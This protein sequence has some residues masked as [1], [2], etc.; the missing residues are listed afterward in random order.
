MTDQ[1]TAGPPSIS[2]WRT[3]DFRL[4]WCGGFVNDIGDWLLMVA[5]PVYVFIQSGSGSATAILFVVEL[6]AA[7]VLGPVG[8]S[9]V[10]RWDLRRTLIVTNLAQAITLVPL[11]TVTGDRIWPAYLVVGAQAMLTQINNPASTAL[12]PRVVAPD[13]LTVANAANSTSASLAR[14]IGSPLGGLA[15]GLGGIGAVVVI[16][17]LTFVA[18]AI[19]MLFVRSHTAPIVTDSETGEAVEPGIRAGVRAVRSHRSL[20]SLILIDSFGQIAQGFF[21]VLF[22]VFIVRQLDGGGVD[23]GLIRGSM[24]V[25][26][27]ISAALIG[28]F[29]DRFGPITLLI[30]GYLGMG[31]V[32]LLFWNAPTVTSALWVYMVVFALSGVPGAAM[33]IGL[34]T[35]VQQFS[36]AGMLGRVVGMA[37]ALDALARAAGSLIAGLLVSQVDLTVLLD[38]QSSIYIACGLLVYLFIHEGRT[39]L[40]E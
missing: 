39:P 8:G 18:V 13:Q 31:G 35:A 21:V 26:G 6:V 40:R 22:V 12:L 33:G 16:D 7:L 25:G 34:F 17:S 10:D 28:K 23:V 19:A 36:P 38:V 27:I 4:V 20:R 29:A 30:A 15:V 24:A 32:S 11:L 1:L 14:L 3:R 9:L 37:G 5:L 2:P